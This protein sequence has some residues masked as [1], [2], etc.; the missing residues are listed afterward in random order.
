[1]SVGN[2]H[3]YKCDHNSRLVDLGY[4]ALSLWYRQWQEKEEEKLWLFI[5]SGNYGEWC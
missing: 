5:D 2:F 4:L 1:M 3:F